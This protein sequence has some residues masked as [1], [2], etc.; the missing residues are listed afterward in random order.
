MHKFWYENS[1]YNVQLVSKDFVKF[2]RNKMFFFL[3]LRPTVALQN[4]CYHR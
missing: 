1:L 3:K 4:V 2:V